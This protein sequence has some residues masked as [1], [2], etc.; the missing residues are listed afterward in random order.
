MRMVL[1]V[2]ESFLSHGSG[3]ARILQRVDFIQSIG[4][5]GLRRHEKGVAQ[6]EGVPFQS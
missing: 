3:L 1:M 5:G 2:C 6:A 4:E